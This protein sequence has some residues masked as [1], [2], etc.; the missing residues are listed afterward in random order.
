M[1]TGS[2]GASIGGS[3]SI[4]DALAR[5]GMGG[6]GATDAVSPTA[7]GFDP[8]TQPAS[9][10]TAQAPGMAPPANTTPQ[11]MP[12]MT[13]MGTPAGSDEA[14]LIVKALSERL[15]TLSQTTSLV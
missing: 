14:G 15:K 12:S 5:R 11:G 8:S 7:P 9:P 13:P 2:F 3:Q 6:V 1:N 4:K 10:V